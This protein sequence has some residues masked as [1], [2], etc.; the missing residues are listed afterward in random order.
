MESLGHH[1]IVG[2]SDEV[3][4]TPIFTPRKFLCPLLLMM[5]VVKMRRYGGVNIR[6]RKVGLVNIRRRETGG[7]K[8]ASFALKGGK[9]QVGLLSP[10]QG[11]HNWFYVHNLSKAFLWLY[12]IE[13]F[14]PT[15]TL[16]Q[17][18]CFEIQGQGLDS[19][20]PKLILCSWIELK[21]SICG[22]WS[23]LLR[24]TIDARSRHFPQLELI[25][26]YWYRS[27]AR[28][29]KYKIDLIQNIK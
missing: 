9:W 28:K 11:T 3:T 19:M 4:T 26:I 21:F 22:S 20:Y 15:I 13:R 29:K 14:L 12:P 6:P 5:R 17:L 16:E 24:R 10:T 25:D 27:S 7:Y 23:G 1:Y 8:S 2:A 18:Q